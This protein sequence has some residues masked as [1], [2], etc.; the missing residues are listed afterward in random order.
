LWAAGRKTHD[1]HM[2]RVALAA[3]GA[4]GPNA[5]FWAPE[6]AELLRHRDATVGHKWIGKQQRQLRAP[7]PG[8]TVS[9]RFKM[10]N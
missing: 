2:C 9:R 10:S 1:L 6:V 7:S 8:R 5:R 3:L 4:M